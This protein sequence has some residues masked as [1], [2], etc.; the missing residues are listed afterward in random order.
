MR[1]YIL[2]YNAGTSNEGIHTLQIGE[3]NKILMFMAQDD[4]ERYALMLEAQDFPTPT[5]EPIDEEEVKAFC[6]NADY[7]CE[8]VEPGKL[9]IPPESNLEPT[10]WNEEEESADTDTNKSESVKSTE[11]D[12]SE[13][14]NEELDRIRSQL[15]G[16]L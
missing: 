16:L 8:L 12:Q 6:K 5:V 3:R 1:V 4:A 14:S 2:L 13:M 11:S 15:E 10:D 9:A 7:D